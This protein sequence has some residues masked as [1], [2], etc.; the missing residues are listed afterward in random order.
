MEHELDA[1]TVLITGGAGQLARAVGE[2]VAAAGAVVEIPGESDLDITS[3]QQ[4][5]SVVRATRP[6]ILI[7]CAALTDVDRCE[8]EP[9]LAQRVNGDAVGILASSTNLVGA[10]LVHVST[11]YVFSGS[12]DRPLREDDATDPINVYGRSKLAGERRAAG[13]AR[14]LIVR[15]AW[16]FGRGGGNFVETIRRKIREG[17]SE[18]RVVD[19]QHG[20][21]TYCDD[22][23][24]QILELLVRDARGV[25]HATNSGHTSWYGLARRIVDTLGADV[26]VLPVP[27]SD[28]PRPA[29]RP[30]WSV[31]DTTLLERLTGRR[32]PRWED[33]L[34]RYLVAT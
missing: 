16:L 4:V 7:N 34:R 17:V 26:R 31:L 29:P 1:E 23:A 12:G 32:P 8:E 22:L 20:C 27:T 2:A 5:E 14:H 3:R 21:P 25:V 13:A 9:E 30:R 19:D 18:L 11:D 6:G 15:T 10:R 28:A 33:A 24:E